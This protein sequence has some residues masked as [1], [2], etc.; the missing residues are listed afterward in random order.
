MGDVVM[1]SVGHIRYGATLDASAQD[2][3]TYRSLCRT[4][5]RVYLIV[6]SDGRQ[7]FVRRFDRVVV[8]GVPQGFGWLGNKV[9]FVLGVARVGLRLARRSGVDV[10]SASDPLFSGLASLALARCAGRPLLVHVQAQVLA[11]P[12][13]GIGILRRRAMESVSRFVCLRADRVRCV[14]R[15]ILR[16]VERLGIPSERIRYLPPR[17]DTSIFSARDKGAR[18][19][20]VRDR[21]GVG[22]SRV[23]LFVGSFTSF[24]GVLNL[25]DA[26]AEVASRVQDAVLVMVGSGPLEAS[27]AHGVKML[28]ISESVMFAGRVSHHD[29]PDYLAAASVLVLPSENEGLPRV[30]LEA[31]AME[32]PIVASAVGGV[33]E[34]VVDGVSGRLVRPGRRADL[35]EALCSA[36]EHLDRS[37]E[38]ARSAQKAIT[39][40]GYDSAENIKRY[41]EMVVELARADV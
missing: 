20:H 14:S 26:F 29:V 17:V 25:V 4:L 7:G 28:G 8:V 35:A 27:L 36:L 5:R 40:G 39:G 38:M 16:C 31:I 32:V 10:V 37:S 9:A 24:K 23:V 11:L 6:A 3:T 12:A 18:G 33:P 15:S 30:I 2:I 34:L 1:L 41:A 21:L 19:R 22:S 13:G